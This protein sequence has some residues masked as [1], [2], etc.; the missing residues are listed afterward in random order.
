MCHKGAIR[1]DIIQKC[2]FSKIEDN[3]ID[4][5]YDN[6]TLLKV[7]IDSENYDLV[8]ACIKSGAN[9]NLQP[10]EYRTLPIVQAIEKNNAKIVE[11]LIKNKAVLVVSDIYMAEMP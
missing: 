7:A 3:G 5:I 11:L 8:K 6:T 9:I 1:E 4:A 10:D 2:V